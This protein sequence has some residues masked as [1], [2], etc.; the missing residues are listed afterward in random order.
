MLKVSEVLKNYGNNAKKTKN[1]S[2]IS[3]FPENMIFFRE[4]CFSLTRKFYPNFI[5]IVLL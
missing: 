4:K 1:G 3:N 2:K 5:G